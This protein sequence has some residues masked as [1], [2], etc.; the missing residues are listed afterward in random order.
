MRLSEFIYTMYVQVPKQAKSIGSPGVKS[1]GGCKLSVVGAEDR[2]QSPATISTRSFSTA[3]P[4]LLPHLAVFYRESLYP[5]YVSTTA[6]GN[7]MKAI[8]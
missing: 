3:A 6:D 4:C 5:C 2:N 7:K 8:Q 1:S